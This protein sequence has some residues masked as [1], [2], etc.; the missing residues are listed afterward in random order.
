MPEQHKELQVH[1]ISILFIIFFCNFFC[2]FCHSD[3]ALIVCV[4]K[5]KRTVEI[6]LL[7]NQLQLIFHVMNWSLL[8]KYVLKYTS[9]NHW[10]YRKKVLVWIVFITYRSR[11][12]GTH[13]QTLDI[14][15]VLKVGSARRMSG[16]RDHL[17]EY[18]GPLYFKRKKNRE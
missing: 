8:S 13:K 1:C 16:V 6:V 14:A 9:N 10:L 4:Y 18:R 15:V 17:A 3:N 7:V 2:V 12:L 11:Y 5:L